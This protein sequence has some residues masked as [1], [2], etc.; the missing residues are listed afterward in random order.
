MS[1][2]TGGS[3]SSF[4]HTAELGGFES[5]SHFNETGIPSRSGKPKPGVLVMANDGVSK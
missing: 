4:C 1:F 3:P 2:I 5:T